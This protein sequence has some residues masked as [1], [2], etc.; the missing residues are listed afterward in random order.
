[1][2]TALQVIAW[3]VAVSF[4]IGTAWVV[5]LTAMRGRR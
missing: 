3:W 4:V 2:S 1:M 5:L